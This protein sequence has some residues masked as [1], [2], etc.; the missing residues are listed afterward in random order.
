M[1]SHNK[2]CRKKFV[3]GVVTDEFLAAI[4]KWRNMLESG[5]SLNDIT[6]AANE[7]RRK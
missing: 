1:I 3:K 5:K 4:A 6:R 2:N 7:M